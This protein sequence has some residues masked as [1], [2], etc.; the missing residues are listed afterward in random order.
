MVG[1]AVGLTGQFVLHHVVLELRQ[2]LDSV[3]ILSHVMEV[4]V[5][6]GKIS[7]LKVA[8]LPSVEVQAI[9]MIPFGLPGLAGPSVL[10]L[11]LEDTVPDHDTAER[12]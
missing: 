10:Q 7:L 8:R 3:S 12:N 11:V 4:I 6:M 9:K 5:V 2:S 1:G